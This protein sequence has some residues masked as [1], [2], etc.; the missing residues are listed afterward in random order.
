MPEARRPAGVSL[1]D[2]INC[3]SI[4]ELDKAF[5]EMAMQKLLEPSLM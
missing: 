2:I 1:T 4:S 3:L 5:D